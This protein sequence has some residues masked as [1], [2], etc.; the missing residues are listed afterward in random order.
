M[1]TPTISIMNCRQIVC[2]V[3]HQES[4]WFPFTPLWYLLFPLNRL[5]PQ[6]VKK[7]PSYAIGLNGQSLFIDEGYVALIVTLM[8]SFWFI[9]FATGTIG[10]ICETWDIWCLTIKPESLKKKKN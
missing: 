4:Y 5:L 1:L 6:F 9:I 3:T 8:T 7:M 10:Q 2:N